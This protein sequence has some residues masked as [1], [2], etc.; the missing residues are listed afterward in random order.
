MAFCTRAAVPGSTF[1][2]LLMVR[3][4]VAVETFALLA[5]SRMFMQVREKNPRSLLYFSKRGLTGETRRCNVHA[6]M[7][8]IRGLIALRKLR[9]GLRRGELPRKHSKSEMVNPSG[10]PEAATFVAEEL[11]K[12]FRCRPHCRDD[13]TAFTDGQY[14]VGLHLRESFE[15]SCGWPLHLDEINHLKLSQAEVQPQIALRHHT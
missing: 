3:E 13:P 1:S 11:V 6:Y 15:F 14:L 2:E 10:E 12:L 7:P 8:A 4:T 9:K 5:T